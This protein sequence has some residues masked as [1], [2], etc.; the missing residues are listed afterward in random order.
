MKSVGVRVDIEWVR[1]HS[2]DEHNRAVDRM[3]R[4]SARMATDSALS[5]VHVRRKLS[6]ESVQPGSVPLQGQ[7]LSIRIITG[8]YLEMHKTWRCKYEVMSKTSDHYMK[9]DFVYCEHLLEAGH[10][11]Y[12]QVCSDTRNPRVVKVFREIQEK[13]KS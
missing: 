6:E 9:V 11:Y 10:S 5:I 8:E 1:G 4:Q 2:K 3:A 13:R 7:R 12:V